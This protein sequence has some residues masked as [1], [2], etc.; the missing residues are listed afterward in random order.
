MNTFHAELYVCDKFRVECFQPMN[1]HEKF[2]MHF[3]S[4]GHHILYPL[5]KF[6]LKIQFISGELKKRNII[7]G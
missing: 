3:F 2:L 6:E 5:T 7:R 1:N 4:I